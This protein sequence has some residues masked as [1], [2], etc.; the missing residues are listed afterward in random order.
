MNTKAVE[1]TKEDIRKA[2]ERPSD[3]GYFGG[4]KE[5]FKT[6]SLGPIIQH[7][8]SDI[9]SQSNTAVLQKMLESECDS[10]EWEILSCNHWAVGWV[11]HISF[12]VINEDG[13]PTTTFIKLMEF[14]KKL[15][16]YP[17]ADEMD[18]S[19]REYE[20]KLESIRYNFPSDLE[21]IGELPEDWESEVFS[22]LWDNDQKALDDNDG[23]IPEDAIREAL[24]DLEFA[25]EEEDE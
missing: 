16:D 18:Y 12:K 1:I 8:D 21:V 6:W 20:A 10:E 13:K 24:L 2:L 14:F 11:E 23:Y 22:W 4:R 17:V 19:N 7:R 5:M 3:F 25:K 15:E 9:L